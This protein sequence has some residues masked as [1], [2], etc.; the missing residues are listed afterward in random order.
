CLAARPRDAR[1]ERGQL[2]RSR[3]PDGRCPEAAPRPLCPGLRALRPERA[4]LVDQGGCAA[5]DAAVR[6]VAAR[7]RQHPHMVVWTGHR[8]SRLATPADPWGK[9]LCGVR[10][11]Q[12]ESDWTWPGSVVSPGR[13][14]RG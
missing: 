4:D 3:S 14:D 7:P 9:W 12:A 1:S 2:E 10:A 5:V 13:R 8:L 6:S 11:V